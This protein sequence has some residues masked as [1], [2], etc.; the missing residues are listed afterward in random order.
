MTDPLE[1]IIKWLAT[2]L[3][4]INGRAANKHRFTDG[5]SKGQ[6]AASVHD[7]DISQ[8]LYGAV[9]EVRVEVRLYG[10]NKA[11]IVDLYRG[12]IALCDNSHRNEVATSQGTA[13]I[14]FCT[15]GTGLTTVFDNDL[16][17]DVGIV[18]LY[19]EIA[20]EAVA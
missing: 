16:S 7:D 6:K 3:T 8:A 1:T 10:S 19:A 15:L 17:Q 13:L 9:H 2:R 5:W 14:Y 18:Y 4:G 11:D 12:L 20:Q